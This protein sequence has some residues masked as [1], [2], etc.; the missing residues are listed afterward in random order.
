MADKPGIRT[1]RPRTLMDVPL[2]DAFL[3]TARTDPLL[4][5]PVKLAPLPQVRRKGFRL[6]L[7]RFCYFVL[8]RT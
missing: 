6:A 3:E 7:R 8:S 4:M 5:P 1:K 2:R